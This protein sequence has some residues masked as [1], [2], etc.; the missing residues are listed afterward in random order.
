[1]LLLEPDGTGGSIASWSSPGSGSS[2]KRLTTASSWS[3]S[4]RFRYTEANWIAL[5][6]S[7]RA[8]PRSAR[9]P[10][11]EASTSAPPRR[12][13]SEIQAPTASSWS[14]ADRPSA[15][16][17]RET[18]QQLLAVEAL[19]P[20][21]ALDHVEPRLLGALVGREALAAGGALAAPAHAVGDRTGVDHLRGVG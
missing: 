9:S 11:R 19:A 1:M 5:T 17:P 4:A 15:G 12:A 3:R 20:A 18:A 7:T 14:G 10:M 8:S 13:S 21:V 6:G 16:R 2:L